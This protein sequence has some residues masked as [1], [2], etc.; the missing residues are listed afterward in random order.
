MVHVTTGINPALDYSQG[1]F[2]MTAICKEGN[3]TAASSP[4][5]VR[6]EIVAPVVTIASE[7][8]KWDIVSLSTDTA[9][10]ASATGGMPVV[11][12]A[13]SAPNFGIVASDPTWVKVPSSSQ[14]TWSTMLSNGYY[15]ICQVWIDCTGMLGGTT[16]T[17][18]TTAVSP[19]D[20]IIYDASDDGWVQAIAGGF[21]DGDNDC[22]DTSADDSGNPGQSAYPIA[23]HYSASNTGKV[24][25]AFG[26]RPIFAQA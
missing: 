9:N 19:G 6:G 5:S 20:A 24:L 4:H 21:D 8:S 2:K 13:V 15:R 18:G 26:L 17:A 22:W 14:T 1:W 7:I 12:T 23:L 3:I 25:I 10:T 11:T 16:T